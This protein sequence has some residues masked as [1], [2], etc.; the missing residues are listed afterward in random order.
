MMTRIGAAV[1]I[2][3]QRCSFRLRTE[4]F[5]GGYFCSVTGFSRVPNPSIST[6]IRSPS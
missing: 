3:P 6:S 4:A 2:A 5:T 1:R